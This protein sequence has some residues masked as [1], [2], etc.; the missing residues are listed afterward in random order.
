MAP[1]ETVCQQDQQH[2]ADA[3][4]HMGQLQQVQRQQLQQGFDPPSHGRQHAGAEQQGAGREG[5][6]ADQGRQEFAHGGHDPL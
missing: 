4:E 6:Q 3:A 2:A 5:A 1:I